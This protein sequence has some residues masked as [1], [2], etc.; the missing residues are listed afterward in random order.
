[1]EVSGRITSI[2]PSKPIYE[3]GDEVWLNIMG[4]AIY[5]PGHD[6]SGWWN[7]YYEVRNSGGRVVGNATITHTIAPWT[8]VDRA[9]DSLSI[10]CGRL[11]LSE[12]LSVTLE[13]N[14]WAFPLGTYTALDERKV[15]VWVREPTVYVPPPSPTPIIPGPTPVIPGIPPGDTGAKLPGWLLPSGI[16][17]AA[18]I[19]L[20]P[21]G[22]KKKRSR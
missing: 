9:D 11:L 20:S 15:P 6:F 13:F 7:T 17:I 2:L 21:S 14:S 10:K 18:L 3:S 8:A 4:Y 12:T 1:M 22:K 16:G 5:R 19:L